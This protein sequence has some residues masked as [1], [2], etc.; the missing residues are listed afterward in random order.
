MYSRRE[1]HIGLIAAQIHSLSDFESYL[2][3]DA[4]SSIW[5]T[6]SWARGKYF[7]KI[8]VW[9]E[10]EKQGTEANEE[11]NVSQPTQ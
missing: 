3:G 6:R 9:K 11:S 5:L 10:A 2:P 4:I 7:I 1:M 8:Q